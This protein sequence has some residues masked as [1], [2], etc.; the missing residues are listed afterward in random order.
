MALSGFKAKNHPQ[1][2]RRAPQQEALVDGYDL[3]YGADD[4]TDD[5]ATTL[6]VF[7]PLHA[8]FGFTIDV[9]ASPA[10]T[11]LPRF[12]TLADDGLAQPWRG[13]RVWCNPPY[14][15]AGGWVA[16]AWQ[17]F[18]R[19]AELIV[20]LL[21]ANRTEQEWWQKWVEPAR[22]DR[23]GGLR[24]EFLPGRLRF[25]K[26]GQKHVGANERPPFGCCLLIWGSDA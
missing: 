23:G 13:E 2:V 8:R 21:P 22:D 5:R 14:S 15:D 3:A 17:E 10:N 6:D 4:D 9:A 7:G 12:Y 20:M 11:K 16:K 24:I 25:L 26:P 19:G 18:N 1:Q